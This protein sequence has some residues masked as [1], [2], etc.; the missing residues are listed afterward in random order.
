MMQPPRAV[1]LPH[2]A[3]RE[4]NFLT[5]DDLSLV[6]GLL[7]E[8]APGW[9]AEL[10]HASPNESTIVV[11]PEDANDLIGPAFVLSRTDRGVELDQFRW[12]E[13]REIGK[14]RFLDGALAAMRARL[15]PLVSRPFRDSN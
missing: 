5:T 6:V 3:N 1:P 2:P 14:F 7:A 8:I 13:Y 10:N 15:V 11:T 12:D 9:S 4:Q